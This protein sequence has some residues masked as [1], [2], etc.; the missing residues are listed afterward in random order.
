MRNKNSFTVE[1]VGFVAGTLHPPVALLDAGRFRFRAAVGEAAVNDVLRRRIVGAAI[2]AA[3]QDASHRLFEHF[4]GRQHD[5]RL[6]R[7]LV[8]ASRKSCGSVKNK[9]KTFKIR[10]LPES[11]KS[12]EGVPVM[13]SFVTPL[14]PAIRPGVDATAAMGCCCC[15]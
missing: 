12:S 10:F 8:L 9:R 7:A 15:S 13:G 5:R 6:L 3:H 2:S 1:I 4:V 14:A 11:P